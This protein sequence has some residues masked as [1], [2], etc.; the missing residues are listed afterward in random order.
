[1]DKAWIWVGLGLGALW[2][3]GS[4]QSALSTVLYPANVTLPVGNSRGDQFSCP[5]GTLFT[6]IASSVVGSGYCS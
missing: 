6:E 5:P 1:M 3:I 4:S 2:L